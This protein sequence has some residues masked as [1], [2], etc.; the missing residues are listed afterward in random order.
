V[1][2]TVFYRK[3]I[4]IDLGGYDVKAHTFEDWHL[5]VQLI[6][7][8]KCLN[9][10]TPLISVRFNPESVTVDEKLR[11]KR[12]A[13]LKKEMILG[14]QP[15]TDEQED[16][17]KQILKSQ[18]FSAFKNYSYHI[19]IAKKYLWNNFQPLKSRQHSLEAIR[20]MPLR[21]VGYLLFLLSLAP[22][23]TLHYL[24]KKSKS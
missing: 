6:K 20:L 1:H 23:K 7:K 9:F 16:E 12:F 4:V 24:H 22:E 3:D 19:L 13:E 11:G 5:W 14:R 21:P 18:N 15:I 10:E 17:L 2:S 8:G